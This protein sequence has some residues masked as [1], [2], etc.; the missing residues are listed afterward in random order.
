MAF[1][2]VGSWISAR[3]IKAKL[4]G[5]MP[6]ESS[7]KNSSFNSRICASHKA[8]KALA[9][10]RAAGWSIR[11]GSMPATS[12]TDRRRC[13]WSRSAWSIGYMK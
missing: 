13:G 5:G 3:Q 12:S 2:S 9:G 7:P 6:W 4:P 10:T 11:A 1:S 8:A